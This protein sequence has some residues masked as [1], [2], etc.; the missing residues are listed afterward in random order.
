MLSVYCSVPSLFKQTV[1]ISSTMIGHPP[2]STTLS[3]PSTIFHETSESKDPPSTVT[4]YSFASQ[5]LTQD[6]S[7]TVALAL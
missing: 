5:V 4:T 1:T 7:S 3:E 2:E 6:P